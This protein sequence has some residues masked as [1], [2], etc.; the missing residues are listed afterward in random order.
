MPLGP[1]YDPKENNVLVKT[2]LDPMVYLFSGKKLFKIDSESIFNKLNYSWS[3]IEKVN[4]SLINQ[5]QPTETINYIDHHLNYTLI[6]Y[7]DTL[8]VYRLE[9]DPSDET[10]QVKRHIKDPQTFNNLHF[11]WDRIVTISNTEVYESG[12]EIN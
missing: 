9:P 8:E 3:W 11:R 7:P 12:V 6:K 1:K 4:Q 2:S 10:K 5:Y